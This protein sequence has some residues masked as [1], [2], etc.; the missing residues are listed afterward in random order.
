M[1]CFIYYSHQVID[2]YD[3]TVIEQIVYLEENVIFSLLS[4]F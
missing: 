2:V 3:R 1:K 4:P